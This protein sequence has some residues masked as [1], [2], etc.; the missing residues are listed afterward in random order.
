MCD[1]RCREQE[2]AQQQSPRR[3]C[4]H[5]VLPV[6]ASRICC[7]I[8][9]EGGHRTVPKPKHSDEGEFAGRRCQAARAAFDEASPFNSS[10]LDR[11]RRLC[12]LFRRTVRDGNSGSQIEMPSSADGPV[13]TLYHPAHRVSFGSFATDPASAADP[14]QTWPRTLNRIAAI[15]EVSHR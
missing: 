15:D 3:G 13:G 5:K 12:G 8:T 10:Q 6:A 4:M 9:N 7:R 1:G 11:C 14:A 2:N